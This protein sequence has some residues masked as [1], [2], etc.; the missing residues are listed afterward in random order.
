MAGGGK[1]GTLCSHGSRSKLR[2]G[3]LCLQETPRPGPLGTR[4]APSGILADLRITASAWAATLGGGLDQ[5]GRSAA[6]HSK[7][8]LLT[9]LDA[10][11]FK[12]DSPVSTALLKHYVEGSGEPYELEAVPAPWQD[13]IVKATGERPGLHRDLNPYNSGLFDLRNSLGHFDVNV[14]ANA[15]NS[16]SYAITD[17]YQFG[18]KANDKAQQGRHGFPLGSLNEWELAAL[19]RLLPDGEYNNPGGFRESWEIKTLGKETVLLIPQ[20]FL[21]RQGKAFKVS[22]GFSR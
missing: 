15:D 20:Q 1:P 9:L 14:T 12:P 8:L 21:A 4:P 13:W 22:G 7:S 18:F 2:D 3:T 17:T 5:L 10:L 19:R 16:K 11:P 6:G